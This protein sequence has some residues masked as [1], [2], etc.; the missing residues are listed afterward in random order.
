MTASSS[1][2]PLD[3][4]GLERKRIYGNQELQTNISRA[5]V[6]HYLRLRRRSPRA[7]PEKSLL[8]PVKRHGGRNNNGRI[9]TRHQGGGHKRR[10][11]LIDFKRDKDG[12]PG[13]VASIEY[14]PNRNAR[15]A[16]IVY[17]DGEKRY[18]LAPNKLKVGDV[19]EAGVG[20]DIKVGNALPMKNIPVG[21]VVHN[22]ELTLGARRADST[23]GGYLGS[24]HGQRGRLRHPASALGR[25]AHDPPGVPGHHR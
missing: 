2:A 3:S 21:T 16:L 12:I 19:V 18:I 15:I 23:F 20:S 4:C 9:T 7:T 11:R 13:N 10:Y 25:D 17:A 6:R 8:A 22:V 24:D 5:Q 1:S 14:D